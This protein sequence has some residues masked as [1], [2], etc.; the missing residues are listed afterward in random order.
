MSE[1]VKFLY[2]N[3]PESHKI[4]SE[5]FDMDLLETAFGGRNSI[6]IDI[7]NYAERMRRSDLARG[8]LIIQTDINL[9]SRHH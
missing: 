4:V 8:V 7:D 5:M 3:N 6:T 2:T 9:I 1:K